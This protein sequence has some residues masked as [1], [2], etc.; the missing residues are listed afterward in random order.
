MESQKTAA[1]LGSSY[2]TASSDSSSDFRGIMNSRMRVEGAGR[3]LPRLNQDNMLKQSLMEMCAG[4]SSTLN[5][6]YISDMD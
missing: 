1:L 3:C 5:E 6:L 2:S 4:F